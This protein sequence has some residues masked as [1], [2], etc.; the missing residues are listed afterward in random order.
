MK[1]II[2]TWLFLFYVIAPQLRAATIRGFVRDAMTGEALSYTNVYLRKEKYGTVTDKNGYYI[3]GSLSPGEYRIVFSMMG[4]EK[5]VR[6]VNLDSDQVLTINAYLSPT[7]ISMK[8]LI[9]SA[10]RERFKH[11]VGVGLRHMGVRNLKFIPGLLEQDLIASLQTLPGIV[12]LSDIS[13]F[14][15]VQGGNP[16]ENLI[17]LDGMAIYDPYHINT[18]FSIFNIDAVKSVDLFG[19]AFP[20]EY[21]GRLSSVLDVET[22]TGN[23]RKMCGKGEISLAS[24]KLMLN[25]P[26]SK[27][28]WLVSARRTY[29]DLIERIYNKIRGR[30]RSTFCFYFYDFYAKVS[31]N[32]SNN[33]MVTL[34]RFS[35]DDVLYNP[36]GTSGESPQV[37]YRYGNRVL[38]LKL[39][40]VVGPKLL[41]TLLLTNNRCYAKDNALGD[42][43]SSRIQD[44]SAKA[45]ISYFH[46]GKHCIK[47]G[48]E[49]KHVNLIS[50]GQLESDLFNTIWIVEQGGET[51]H[52][53][54]YIQDEYKSRKFIMNNGIRLNYYLLGR[55]FRI[56]PRFQFK[57]LLDT[58]FA[59][60]FA[61]GHYYQFMFKPLI[62]SPDE[63]ERVG[64]RAFRF[65]YLSNEEVRPMQAI[66]YV[67]GTEK[68][69][70]NNVSLNVEIYYKD[71]KNLLE[72]DFMKMEGIDTLF[73]ERFDIGAGYTFGVDVLLKKKDGWISYTYGITK[74]N[75]GG[76]FYPL[77]DCRHNF[78]ITWNFDVKT[79]NL[80]MRWVYRSGLPYTDQVG[81]YQCIDVLPEP[82]KEH[83]Y[84]NG[85]GRIY[86]KYGLRTPPY[87][88]LDIILTKGFELFKKFD[89]SFFF[90]ILNVYNRKNVL[91]YEETGYK[92]EEG[93]TEIKP[94]G[95]LPIF[96]SIGITMRF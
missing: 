57:Y 42:I 58:D 77:Q 95:I 59:F 39:R 66:H 32:P 6:D 70:S 4:Y 49:L 96:P 43:F 44:I 75:I 30:S 34:L 65:W 3:I 94:V 78:N 12:T 79:W 82:W 53:A 85:E 81:V 21:G 5:L 73:G 11:E 37:D 27:G 76:T 67:I 20:A 2:L 87:H 28:S 19:G 50:K 16:D 41:C 62:S 88:R 68:W 14:L 63:G 80:G 40:Y 17:L 36:S 31:F 54:A 51:S 86:A 72:L 29:V 15:Y 71:M 24:S 83:P 22:K 9:V 84:L 93:R 23:T 18:L 74:R 47:S 89:S 33:L 90:Q 10:E 91:Y 52:Y 7:P 64:V 25:G 48:Y 35:S 8:E 45:N 46:S 56:S 61:Y 1:R 60:K 69:L 92:D 13:N 38:G 26:I 55:Y